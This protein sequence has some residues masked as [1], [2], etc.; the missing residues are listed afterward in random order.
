M[1]YTDLFFSLV[2]A[3]GRLPEHERRRGV[4]GGR[5]VRQEGGFGILNVWR[6]VPMTPHATPAYAAAESSLPVKRKIKTCICRIVAS[7]GVHIYLVPG[8]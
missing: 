4:C 5:R 8:T 1:S 7:A 2:G 6:F 3:G